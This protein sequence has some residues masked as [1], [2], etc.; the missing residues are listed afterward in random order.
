MAFTLSCKFT[1][2]FPSFILLWLGKWDLGSG[3]QT[4]QPMGTTE[5]VES[6]PA[7]TGEQPRHGA[8]GALNLNL[9]WSRGGWGSS[10]KGGYS[11]WGLED[12][13]VCRFRGERK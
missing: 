11:G 13:K 3:N 2:H 5:V 4:G 10:G 12:G 7:R 9:A 8:R 6:P 1:K